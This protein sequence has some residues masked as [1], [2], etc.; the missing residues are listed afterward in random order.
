M[1]FQ[2]QGKAGTFTKAGA[3]TWIYQAPDD[4]GIYRGM[5]TSSTADTLFLRLVG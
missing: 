2:I 3:H 4:K 5:I 1:V